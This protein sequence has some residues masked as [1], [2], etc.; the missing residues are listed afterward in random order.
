MQHELPDIYHT[1]RQQT[2]IWLITLVTFSEQ[3]TVDLMLGSG[4]G[5]IRFVDKDQNYSALFK[6]HYLQTKV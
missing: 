6:S 2:F 1:F 3:G 4:R 5:S